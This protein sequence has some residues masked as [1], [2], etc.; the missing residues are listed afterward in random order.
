M[1]LFRKID[2]AIVEAEE[3][4]SKNFLH[5]LATQTLT[6]LDTALEDMKIP[7]DFNSEVFLTVLIQEIVS[8]L[9]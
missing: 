2:N 7:S 3:N 5:S 8:V 1:C 6:E 9:K 4:E